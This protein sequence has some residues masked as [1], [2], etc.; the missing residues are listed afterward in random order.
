MK[1]PILI[2]TI[3]VG[4]AAVFCFG[5]SSLN[6]LQKQNS[7]TSENK[8]ATA[9]KTSETSS[10][11][12]LCVNKFYPV[13]NGLKRN[14][15]NKIGGKT[16]MTME[17]K[18]GDASFTEVTTLKDVTVKHVWN[19]TS[20][21]LVAANYGSSAEMSNMQ[22]EP[23]HISGVT[24]PAENEIKIGKSWT[25]VYQATG[26]SQLGAIDTKVELNNKIVSLDDEVKTSAGTFK[27][28]KI[29]IEIVSDM[30]LGG[31]KM[32]VPK[33]Q[34]AVWFA[35]EVGMV[36]STGGMDGFS[37]TMEYTGSN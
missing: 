16:K 19:C 11:T 35:P 37:N 18:D 17:Y 2:K 15:D 34:S 8:V 28:V 32:P 12:S 36:K 1:I 6:P 33:I 21:G 25:A 29:E 10:K 7:Q 26:S 31:K 22:L 20:E 9:N 24:L 23:K 13:K 3:S 5:C 4:L 30:K 14:Y 27:A